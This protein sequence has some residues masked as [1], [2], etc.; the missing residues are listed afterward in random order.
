MGATDGEYQPNWVTLWLL[1]SVFR[2]RDERNNRSNRNNR[3]RRGNEGKVRGVGRVLFSLPV[4]NS[5]LTRCMA[6]PRDALADKSE[7]RGSDV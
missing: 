4:S 1:Y 3:G 5:G 6:S 7:N 2:S